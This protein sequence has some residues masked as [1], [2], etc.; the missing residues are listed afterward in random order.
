M[1]SK[2]PTLSQPRLI[3]V[4]MRRRS[5]PFPA[6][7]SLLWAIST[8][9]QTPRQ[10]EVTT[11]CAAAAIKR[12]LVVESVVKNSE[13]ERAG[14]AEGDIILTWS[15]GV[16]IGKVESPFDLTEIETEQEPR[17]RVTLIGT[18]GRTTQK[19]KMGP[20][21][22]GIQ[23]RP[24]LRED[25]LAIYREG[26]ALAAAGKLG[27]AAERWRAADADL[28]T[29][30]SSWSRAWLLFQAAE[31]LADAGQ[32]KDSDVLFAEMLGPGN[33][34]GGR[35]R[36]QL[37]GIWAG[38]F[39]Q[40]GDV[41]NADTYYRRSL[42][43]MSKEDPNS[44]AVAANL[45]NLGK[46]AAK[47]EHFAKAEEYYLQA[48]EIRRKLA[49]G[50]LA[51]AA[52][53][54]D[55][56]QVATK[57]GQQPEAEEYYLQ[58]L[59]IRRKLTPGSFDLAESLQELGFTELEGG[60]L[61]RA[62]EYFLQ[63]LAIK[64]KLGVDSL[65]V[66]GSIDF[67]GGMSRRRGDLAKAEEYY[68]QALENRRKLA[69]GSLAVSDSLYRIG[70]VAIEGGDLVK[71]E[72]CH[73]QA[74][75]IREKVAPGG[76][77]VASSISALGDVAYGRGDLAKAEKYY[78]QSLAIREKRSPGSLDLAASL[79]N[80]GKVARD[81]GAFAKAEQYYL[82]SLEIVR[83]LDADSS[84]YVG[85]LAGTLRELQQLDEA[86][87]KYREMIDVIE[88][89]GRYSSP[90]S[91][92]RA[93]FTAKH[94]HYYSEYADLLLTQ[95]QP[96]LAFQVLER[97][98]ARTL[99][100]MLTE[101]HVDIR[102]G[103]DPMLLDR[104]RALQETLT[105][106]SNRKISL[107]EGKHTDEQAA[108]LNVEINELFSHYQDVEGQIRIGSPNYAAL[109]QP[110]PLNAKEAQQ[111]LLDDD[112]VLLEYDLGEKRSFV[113]LLTPTALDFHELPKRSEIEDTSNHLY[114]LL[115]SRN[116]WIGGETSAQHKE[117]L[118]KSDAEYRQ[119]AATLSQMV[120]GP[121]GARLEGKRVLIVAD[122]ALLYIPFA[123]LP[124]AAKDTTK[125]AVQMVAEH[126]V[127]NLPSAS[128]LALL[129]RQ[130]K[131]RTPGP[132]EVAVLADPVF[133]K[134]DPRVVRATKNRPVTEPASA[135]HAIR[136]EPESLFSEQLTRSLGDVGLG[137]RAL[138]S[139]LP[140]LPFS[141][142]EA[143]AIISMTN[144]GL[145][146]KALDFQA[147]RETAVSKDLGQFR[148]VHF[149]THGL[150]DDEHPELSGLVL[151]MVDP[152]GKPQDGFLDLEDVY[153]LTLPADLVVLSACETG[154]GKQVTG[155]GLVGLTRGFMYA[156]ASRV[157]AS[158]WKVDDVA[159]AELM[160]RFYRGMLKEG[161]RPAAAL[162]QAQMEMQKQRRW[163]EP[164]YW[165]AFTLQGE[166][167]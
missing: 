71:A 129:R 89:Q 111:Q 153:N 158:L 64:E 133:G 29:C 34:L 167:Q 120:L 115:T 123:V 108:T 166:W 39:L 85:D 137:T 164:Y 63:A 33:G 18:R 100:D 50:S 77:S 148:I 2:R 51:V 73:S 126:E 117:R 14:L 16:A 165:A 155:E 70:Q 80:L 25:L 98:R 149:A 15:R 150:L 160:G 114:A 65:D 159:T 127:V 24:S 46:I 32:W 110:Q 37:L 152:Q 22:W 99:L 75:A 9:G 92:Y 157:V 87:Q 62:D 38:R 49:P 128:V 3:S 106:T 53:L 23:V 48:L 19:W 8:S 144:P 66:I 20:D 121:L 82:Q 12:G 76:V 69:P 84:D 105:A 136:S 135:K 132:K 74:L 90:T 124:V 131:D 41:N 42:A 43:L 81:S 163:S 6:L 57:R 67:L 54:R 101:A 5:T 102:Q 13:G 94:A 140:R 83:R 139:A 91:D 1:W 118:A 30:Q 45:N 78:Q 55:L 119:T 88:N 17:G 28:E 72:E 162:R 147:S 95:K 52:S 60:R 27:D 97:L 26:Q 10:G 47:N 109:T 36:A 96:E 58:A 40:R 122:G 7:F 61:A 11:P 145:G 142:R 138:G 93:A 79:G 35:L 141:R 59:E 113:F 86:A 151:S 31:L 68:L 4:L 134:D 104:E 112:T 56:G 107:L 44:L 116:R 143:D 130:S 161:L 103:A 154:L 21:K 156:G 146:M 125:P